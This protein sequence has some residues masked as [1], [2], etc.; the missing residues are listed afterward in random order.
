MLTE[1]SEDLKMIKTLQGN[2]R[3]LEER[4]RLARSTLSTIKEVMDKI[5]KAYGPPGPLVQPEVIDL[6]D[7]DDDSETKP[8]KRGLPETDEKGRS[9]KKA[10]EDPPEGVQREDPPEGVQVIKVDQKAAA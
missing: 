3:V 2:F 8:G 7:S 4:L 9:T 10:R 1:T 6:C 5:D